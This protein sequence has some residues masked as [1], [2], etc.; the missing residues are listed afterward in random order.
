MEKN[1]I[2]K[3]ETITVGILLALVGGFF[4]AYTY[5]TRDGVFA[6]AQSGN[7]I[8]LG[9]D[10]ANGKIIHALSYAVPIITYTFGIIL[11]ELVHRKFENKYSNVH[12]RQIIIG[13]EF[14]SVSGVAFIPQSNSA[15]ANA[16][17]SLIC[18][19][20]V[21]SFRKINGHAFATT[22]CTGNLRSGTESLYNYIVQ[23]NPVDAKKAKNYFMVIFTFIIGAIVGLSI[24]KVFG[25]Y[26]VLLCSIILATVFVILKDEEKDISYKKRSSK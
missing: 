14:L 9:M 11:S 23:R 6:N 24:S 13:I 22:M 20:Q 5:T 25:I 2:K 19:V 8:L 3:S 12:W 26:A 10:L 1:N 15:L 4:D 16:I 7:I 17:I 21:Q 18:A